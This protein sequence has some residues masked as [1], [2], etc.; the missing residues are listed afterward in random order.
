MADI[1]EDRPTF[2]S[3]YVNEMGEAMQSLEG[4][5]G[6][7]MDLS[8]YYAVRDRPI[9]KWIH[10]RVRETEA[11]RQKVSELYESVDK[12]LRDTGMVNVPYEIKGA[13][14]IR[15]LNDFPDGL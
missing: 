11:M 4:A 7:L 13:K 8:D 1:D 3:M 10:D 5:A 2:G 6:I 12:D 15:I 9:P 14:S